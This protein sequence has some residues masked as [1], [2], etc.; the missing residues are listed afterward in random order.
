MLEIL[1][2]KHLLQFQN[3]PNLHVLVVG[4]QFVQKKKKLAS[5]THI[6]YIVGHLGS[7][8]TIT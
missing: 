2:V 6:R 5:N 1:S 7:T 8:C 3:I 4:I